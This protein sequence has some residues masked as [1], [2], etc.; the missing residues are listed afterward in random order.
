MTRSWPALGALVLAAILV[1]SHVWAQ[2]PQA[3]QPAV[4]PANI[5]A[6]LPKDVAFGRFV[7]Q[8]RAH[9]ATGDELVRQRNW[10]DA[11]P[12]FRF[13]SEEIYGVIREDLS[14]YRTPPFDRALK[15]LARTVKVR[16]LKQY[17]KALLKVES[18]LAATDT[19]LKARQPNWPHFV[20]QVA[21]AT[22]KVAPDEY[23]DAVAKGR[24][25]RPIG[26]QTARGFI[27][28]AERM[29]ESVAGDLSTD[30]AAALGD[31]RAGFAQLKQGFGP[32]EPPKQ[33]VLD[34]SAVTAIVARIELAA[35]KLN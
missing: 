34:Y 3:P 19:A 7:A 16:G 5:P 28:Q 4:T 14:S 8:I 23:D 29:I 31:I 18:V 21:I 30:Q 9:L 24:I 22:L 10:V 17:P 15:E 12:H 27:L 6:P 33:P 26:Y 1:Q 13:P 11:H 20:T 35:A 25:V 32:V 2:T